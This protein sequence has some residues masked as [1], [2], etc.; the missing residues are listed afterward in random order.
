MTR[1]AKIAI[2]LPQELLQGIQAECE[3]RGQTRSE[4][5][6][7]AVVLYLRR[8]RE[9]ELEERYVRGYLDMPESDEEVEWTQSAG[10]ASL[11]RD[12]WEK[13]KNE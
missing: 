5:F 12:P 9:R 4:F 8:Q 7:R 1:S 13:G 2:S 11:S 6:R 10:L 3:A